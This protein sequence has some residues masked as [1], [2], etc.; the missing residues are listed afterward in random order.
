MIISF[1]LLILFLFIFFLS[2]SLAFLL[3]HSL[4]LILHIIGLW[5]HPKFVCGPS[6]DDQIEA[7]AVNVDTE[8]DL[9]ESFPPLVTEKS[10]KI[11]I[12]ILKKN[13]KFGNFFKI[14]VFHFSI[15][16][17][18]TIFSGHNLFYIMLRFFHYLYDVT[19]DLGT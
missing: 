17:K 9:M 13:E 15:F 4:S 11:R 1:L 14:Y 7:C 18:I 19:C 6:S 5:I 10:L 3:S 12:K 16:K 2:L 8:P